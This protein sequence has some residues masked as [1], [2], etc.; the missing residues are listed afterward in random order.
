MQGDR[1]RHAA[2]FLRWRPDKP[3]AECR[4]DQLEVTTPYELEK[5]FGARPQVAA[6]SM[7]RRVGCAPVARGYDFDRGSRCVLRLGP[8]HRSGTCCRLTRMRVHV[9]KAAAHR[10][11]EHVGRL[12]MR[13]RLRV[14]RSST[15]EPRERVL[16][17]VARAPISISGCFGIR[18]RD[19][20]T[21][22]RFARLLS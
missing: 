6:D 2:I 1:F 15:L 12:E 13:G 4:Y 18:R 11:D 21:R 3:P 8:P 7:L 16:L 20:C 9:S 10:V 19:G 22:A 14:P 5:V 17:A